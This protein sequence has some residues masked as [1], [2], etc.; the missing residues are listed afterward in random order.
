MES[1]HKSDHGIDIKSTS[2]IISI[3]MESFH[4]DNFTT[5]KQQNMRRIWDQYIIFI[6]VTNNASIPKTYLLL[7]FHSVPAKSL[8]NRDNKY[9][10]N[11]Q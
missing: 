9:T 11:L 7:I 8:Q 6:K 3:T 4:K 1:Q 5:C 2:A 10:D